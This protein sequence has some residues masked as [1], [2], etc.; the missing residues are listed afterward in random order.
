VVPPL[1]NGS[2]TPFRITMPS[3][4]GNC[5]AEAAKVTPTREGGSYLDRVR[6]CLA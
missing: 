5:K 4:G 6:V 1:F 2:A 3:C